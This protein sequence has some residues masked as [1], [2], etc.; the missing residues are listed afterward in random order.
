MTAVWRGA[1]GKQIPCGDAKKGNGKDKYR[2]LFASSL[3]AFGQDDSVF[4]EVRDL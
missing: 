2:G 3:R 1:A 4:R